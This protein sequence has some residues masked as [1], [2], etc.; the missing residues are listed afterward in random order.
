MAASQLSVALAKDRSSCAGGKGSPGAGSGPECRLGAAG[1]TSSLS[2]AEESASGLPSLSL[3]KLV[4]WD[5]SVLKFV[6]NTLAC[7]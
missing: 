1:A 3:L 2:T 6:C 4:R 7:V 5:P